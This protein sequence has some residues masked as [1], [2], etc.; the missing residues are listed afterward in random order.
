[1]KKHR[2]LPLLGLMMCS[3]A[4][5]KIAVHATLSYDQ[6]ESWGDYIVEEGQVAHAEH[7]ESGMIIEGEITERIGD[8]VKGHIRVIKPVSQKFGN[9]NIGISRIYE[10][11][12]DKAFESKIGEMQSFTFKIGEK[13]IKL[14]VTPRDCEEKK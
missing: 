6:E 11:V 1:M 13:E 9:P 12:L 7:T 5:A 10:S 4:S 2:I 8:T 14:S 3:L